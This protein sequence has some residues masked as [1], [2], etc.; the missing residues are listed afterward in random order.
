MDHQAGA[1]AFQGGGEIA[2]DVEPQGPDFGVGAVTRELLREASR[3]VR[4]TAR[5]NDPEARRRGQEAA[6]AAAEDP[7]AADDQDGKAAA[8]HPR[9][10]S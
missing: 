9:S 1:G 2:V 7:V 4:G 6:K 3:L 5:D 8:A 10:L